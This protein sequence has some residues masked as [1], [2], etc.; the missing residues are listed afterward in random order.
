MLSISII[1]HI[2]ATG[3]EKIRFQHNC[4][5]IC[6]PVLPMFPPLIFSL[7]VHPSFC[8]SLYLFINQSLYYSHCPSLYLL[9]HLSLRR[10]LI[11]L[12]L[13]LTVKCYS[14]YF[15]LYPSLCPSLYLSVSL[16]LCLSPSVADPDRFGPDPDPTSDNRP[17]SDPDPVKTGSGFI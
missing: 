12:S 4:C 6:A 5:A 8:P 17:D 14:D 9:C 15:S 3:M 2:G 7:Y 16:F 13:A 1:F 10:S 11:S